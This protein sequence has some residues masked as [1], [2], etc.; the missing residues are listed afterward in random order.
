MQILFQSISE[1][2]PG[3]KW[4][5]WFEASWPACR[6]WFLKEGDS[7]RPNYL[8]CERAL[9]QHMPELVPTYQ[10]LVEL[11][12]GSDQA[13][14]M[15]S[16]YNPTPFM[17]GCS[18]AVWTRDKPF[19]VRNYDYHAGFWEAR[20]WHSDWNGRQV[21]AMIDCLWGVLDGINDCGLAVSLAFGGRKVVGD[22]F[23]IPVIL[24]YV[25]EFCETTEQAIESLGRIP[26][27]MAYTVTI[28]D[29]SGTHC[30]IFLSPDRE[31]AVSRYPLATNHQVSVEWD[32]HERVTASVDRAH[33][34]SIR[35]QDEEETAGR[36]VDRFLEPPLYQSRHTQGW[37][38][39][40][41]TVYHPVD[42]QCTLRWPGF[43][44]EQ[45]ISQFREQSLVI[46]F[47]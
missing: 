44:L 28:L 4:R 43:S 22:G 46:R 36:F 24:R 14:R 37:G 26:C 29:E 7:A 21:I 39:L 35:L 6:R 15:L 30:T 5:S 27:H 20:L 34:L 11:S 2:Q 33:F 42:R 10:R 13:A 45:A 25:L 47:D 17:T 16:L 19:L 3:E 23:G 9:K 38:T 18:Q 12:G 32:E 41:T 40:Y 31:P 1:L 8:A